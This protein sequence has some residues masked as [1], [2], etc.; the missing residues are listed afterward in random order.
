MG[1]GV[2]ELG[3]GGCL[4]EKKGNQTEGYWEDILQ[5]K[6]AIAEQEIHTEWNRLSPASFH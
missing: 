6:E 4:Y 5:N 2:I 1:N 3:V